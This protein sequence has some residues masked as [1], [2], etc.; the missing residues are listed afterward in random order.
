MQEMENLIA[1]SRTSHVVYCAAGGY[2]GECV[3]EGK[4]GDCELARKLQEM[5]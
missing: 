3:K 1:E 2:K 5:L 4:K